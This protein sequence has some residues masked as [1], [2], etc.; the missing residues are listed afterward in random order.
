MHITL[1]L[2]EIDIIWSVS[3]LQDTTG[4]LQ[5]ITYNKYGPS[6]VRAKVDGARRKVW[7]MSASGSSHGGPN[8]TSTKSICVAT[9]SVG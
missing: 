5:F 3:H 8:N 6:V 9:I 1:N 2:Q 4:Y 7:T